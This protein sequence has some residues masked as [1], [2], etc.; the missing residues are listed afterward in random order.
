AP[1]PMLLGRKD[2]GQ[3]GQSQ[4]PQDLQLFYACANAQEP[5]VRELLEAKVNVNLRDYSW[6]T[7]LHVACSVKSSKAIGVVSA[8]IEHRAEVNAVDN[9]DMNPINLAMNAHNFRVRKLLEEHGGQLQQA[10]EEKARESFWLLKPSEFQIKRQIAKTLK[11]VVH[12]ADW[13]GTLVVLKC[14]EM[15]QRTMMRNLRKSQSLYLMQPFEVSDDSTPRD[16]AEKHREKSSADE[17]LHEIQ[18]VASLRHPDLVL[19][20]GA[21]LEPEAPVMF[22]TE[23]M[24]GGDLEHYLHEQRRTRG[25]DVWAPSFLQTVEWLSAVCRALA[26]LH[27]CSTPIIHRDLKPLNLLLTKNLEVKVT[28]FGISKMMTKVSS[29]CMSHMT[30]GV[31]TY[32]YMAPEVVRH[33]NYDEKVDIYSLGLIMYFLSSGKRPFCHLGITPQDL[34]DQFVKGKEPRPVVEDCHRAL[35]GLMVRCWAVQ[36]EQR[37]SAEEVLAELKQMTDR[38]SCESCEVM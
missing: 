23:Y 20:L 7:P 33:Q 3:R 34:L 38:V 26:F 29:K 12:L 21:C 22:V 24:A 28:D 9:L 10:L 8:L 17:M 32:L 37:P 1:L 31:G 5:K 6:R 4:D 25:F 11:S 14:A 2:D 13:H 30:G 36:R 27:N 18:L 16:K 19:F 35:R 15:H